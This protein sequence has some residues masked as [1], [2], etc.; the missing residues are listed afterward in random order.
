MIK[1]LSPLISKEQLDNAVSYYMKETNNQCTQLT[2]TNLV[3]EK[4]ALCKRLLYNGV[5]SST[6]VENILN[7]PATLLNMQGDIS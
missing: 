7:N 6:E 5:L 3:M 2:A 1:D 4:A